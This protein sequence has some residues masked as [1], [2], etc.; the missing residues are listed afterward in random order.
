MADRSRVERDKKRICLFDVG[1]WVLGFRY[2]WGRD[3]GPFRLRA[4]DLPVPSFA[5]WSSINVRAAVVPLSWC[6]MLR[7]LG[8]VFLVII[9]VDTA[10]WGLAIGVILCVAWLIAT[11]AFTT[12]SSGIFEKP[13]RGADRRLRS[14][15]PLAH[16]VYCADCDAITDSDHDACCSCGS[17]SILAVTRL[18]QHS[19]AY[20]PVRS[21][22]YK[23]SFTADVREIPAVG[24]SEA[25]NRMVSLA[26]LGGDLENFHIQVDAV[27]ASDALAE[28]K[29]I[30][31]VKPV[32][33][34]ANAWRSTQRQ[35]S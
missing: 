26:E 35:A 29:K 32:A 3:S 30:E 8:F 23:I 16:A 22:K 7:L 20:E 2:R 15:I 17:R 18:W 24:L 25:I 28:R 10:P 9:C 34:P 27:E 4:P 11:P 31:L 12:R 1:L 33:R 19:V 14:A 13:T 21:A 6:P 5:N